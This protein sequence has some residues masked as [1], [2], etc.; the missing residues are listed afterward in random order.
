M[1]RSYLRIV[2]F[3]AVVLAF[4]CGTD[5][6][7][8]GPDMDA[9][10]DAM[11]PPLVEGG[12]APYDSGGAMSVPRVPVVSELVSSA[13]DVQGMMFAA[14]EMQISGEPF[15]QFFGGRNL[16]YYNRLQLPPDLYL[17][18]TP[19]TGTLAGVPDLFGFST[20]VE[21]YEYSKYHVNSVIQFSGAGVSLAN[22]PVVGRRGEATAQDRLIA[23]ATGLMTAAGTDVGGLAVLPPPTNNPLNLIGFAGLVPVFAP[24]S[25][26]TPDIPATMAVV[27]SCDR[28]GGYSGLLTGPQTAAAYECEYNE[29]HVPDAQLNHMLVPGVLG[30]SI[31][32]Q[33]LWSIDFA[34]RLHDSLSNPVTSV[35]AADGPMVGA[36]FNMV[37]AD[38]PPGAAVGTYIGSS[39]LEGMWG[40]VMI[41]GMDNLDEWLL[42]SLTTT[43]GVAL[44]GF[45]S[46]ADAINY[47]YSSPLRWFPTAT[48]VAVDASAPY[49]P[50]TGLTLTDATSRSVDL[51]GL[52]LGNG[53]FFA[54]TDGRNPA[55]GKSAG[56]SLVFDGDPFPKDNGLPDGEATAHDRAL[57]VLRVAFVDLERMH[58]EPTLGVVL[59]SATVSA[60]AITRGTTVTTTNL[61]H[62]L[63]SLRQAVLSLNAAVTQYGSADED[64][65]GDAQGILNTVAIHPPGG[66]TPPFSAHVRSLFVKNAVFVRDVLTTADGHVVNGATIS[67]GKATAMTGAASLESQGAAVRALTEAFLLTGDES[68]RTRARAV[69]RHL[70]DAFYSAPARMYRG[71]EGGKDEVHMTPIRFGWLQSALRETHKT[72]F[73]AG[74]KALDRIVLED[75]IARINKLFMNGWDD[76]NGDQKV[77]PS[78]ECLAGRLQTGEQSLTGELG[79][80]AKGAPIEDRDGDCVQVLWKAKKLSVFAGDVLFHSP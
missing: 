16:A 43:D 11:V 17:V 52:I 42:T 34:G 66:G 36:P 23:R 80:D 1:R 58:S 77:D 59:D 13:V 49:P 41:D 76:I 74:D 32:K 3:A 4:A 56:L 46:T 47:D 2:P 45:A 63:V 30:F 73:V 44:S 67:G 26:F 10:A 51:A 35:K 5:D 64:P 29:L 68:F 65:S 39:P 9:G 38:A 60:G 72:L 12:R 62:V 18:P 55:F 19:G 79:H 40:L 22:G 8:S 20:A 6:P 31:W 7:G 69:S 71:Q 48:T 21:S 50:V 70:Q 61:A 28:R 57:G 75:R 37:I 53:L 33:A 78:K 14:G 54:M 15:A 24:Y 25:S 27:K